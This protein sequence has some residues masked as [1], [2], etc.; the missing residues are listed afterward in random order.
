MVK[1][2]VSCVANVQ[3]RLG[4]GP[5]W[6]VV[7]QILYWTDIENA[8]LHAL[9][10]V[11][12]TVR[13]WPMPERLTCVA[14]RAR[15][16]LVVTFA[17]GFAFLDV[18]TGAVT[19]LCSPESGMPGNRFNDGKCDRQ[20]RFWAGTM[21]N[22]GVERSGA[23]YRLNPDLSCHQIHRD[24]GIPNSIAVSPD[25]GVLYF[26]DTMSGAIYQYDLDQV[27]G[28]L[29]ARR[30]FARTE[31]GVGPDGSTVDAEGYLWNAQWNGWRVVR[32]AP[33]GRIDR[34]IELPVQCP[35][36]CAFGGPDLATLYITSA[37]VGL[38]PDALARQPLAGG[39]LAIEGLG[40]RGL[41][42]PD[43]AG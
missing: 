33:D 31:A 38:A 11:D 20:G 5:H 27:T 41:A 9:S 16:G 40:V 13:Q 28:T 8:V 4:E 22:E 36:C 19:R 10:P 12:G 39:L 6:A 18:A 14:T 29:G 26:A 25:G 7:E 21:H 1:L 15:G 3:N 34:V 2:Q 32:Y 30:E 23:L 17:S 43:F 37:R 24:V 35:T 42:E